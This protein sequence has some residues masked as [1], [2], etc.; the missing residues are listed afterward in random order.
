VII[1]H[2]IALEISRPRFDVYRNIY[3][4]FIPFLRFFAFYPHKMHETPTT[5]DL[6]LNVKKDNLSP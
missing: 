6:I 5:E 3:R 1:F 4:I 2:I